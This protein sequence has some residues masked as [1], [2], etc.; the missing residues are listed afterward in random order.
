[1]TV[2]CLGIFCFAFIGVG[3]PIAVPSVGTEQ[4]Q[5]IVDITSTSGGWMVGA[6]SDA[7]ISTVGAEE[8]TWHGSCLDSLLLCTTWLVLGNSYVLTLRVIGTNGNDLAGHW[9]FL[10]GS[11]CGAVKARFLFS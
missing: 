3:G 6:I 1:M 8:E 2:R 10:C 4:G 7:V 9:F 5:G 11:L